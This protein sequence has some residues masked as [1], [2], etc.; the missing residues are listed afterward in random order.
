M[1]IVFFCSSS[2][3]FFSSNWFNRTKSSPISGLWGDLPR[4]FFE[5]RIFSFEFWIDI[6]PWFFRHIHKFLCSRK[7]LDRKIWRVLKC[8]FVLHW[9]KLTKILNWRLEPACSSQRIVQC[10][11]SV[12]SL[13]ITS[14]YLLAR[15]ILLC[16]PFGRWKDLSLNHHSW[17]S[18][19][20]TLC[21]ALTWFSVVVSKFIFSVLF[22]CLI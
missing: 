14:I 6:K 1:H 2:K 4:T 15:M 3:D 9:V 17:M 21:F 11:F 16:C 5:D 22:Y 18:W 8:Q 13:R 10:R 19:F 7:F 20:H 12:L